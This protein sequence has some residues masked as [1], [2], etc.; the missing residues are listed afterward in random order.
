MICFSFIWISW[1]Q[2]EKDQFFQ[3][4]KSNN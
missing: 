1:I 3:R 2:N 4:T